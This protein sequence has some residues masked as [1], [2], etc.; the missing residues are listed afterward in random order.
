MFKGSTASTAA[1]ILAVL[2]GLNRGPYEDYIASKASEYIASGVEKLRNSALRALAAPRRSSTKYYSRKSVRAR[3]MPGKR[4][5]VRSGTRTKTRRKT[6]KRRRK[7]KRTTKKKKTR[8]TKKVKCFIKQHTAVHIHRHRRSGRVLIS[9]VGQSNYQEFTCTGS[10]NGI[11]SAAANL[12]YFDPGTNA[13][14]VADPTSGTYQRELC[15]SITRRVQIRNNYQVP[16]YVQLWNC[17]PKDAT[18][19]SVASMFSSGLSDQMITP[20][21]VSPLMQLTDSLDLKN[22]WNC[23]M[24]VNRRLMPGQLA[25]GYGNNK[26]FEYTISTNDVHTLQYQKK[27]GGHIFFLRIVGEI[28]HDSGGLNEVGV[29][30]AGVD[31]MCDAVV[32]FEYD[33]GKNLHEF[34]LDDTSA[35][36]FTGGG[37]LSNNP[38]VDNQSYSVN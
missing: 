18:S 8:F 10:L 32:R 2:A 4:I 20:N 23:K 21:T 27:Q 14:V 11:E 36:S 19:Q 35:S 12:R 9:T 15:I 3:T 30:T 6:R 25:V 7:R 31:W 22:V 29:G 17:Y 37:I 38:V 26:M 28:Q 24:V 34:S 13:L 5:G 1:G 16:V 33:A